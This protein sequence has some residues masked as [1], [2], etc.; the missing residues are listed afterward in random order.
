MS[1]RSLGEQLSKRFLFNYPS[2]RR[3]WACY[4]PRRKNLRPC[5]NENSCQSW[6]PLLVTLFSSYL[7]R[8]RKYVI[9]SAET[10]H[11]DQTILSVIKRR[12]KDGVDLMDLILGQWTNV[13]ACLVTDDDI[14]VQRKQR[15]EKKRKKKKKEYQVAV[16][17]SESRTGVGNC[18]LLQHQD[19]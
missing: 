14:R 8:V 7:R 16:K 2:M 3:I 9:R 10:R 18:R 15:D 13:T 12:K 19:G 5:F 17:T 1:T 6:S 11:F 4:R